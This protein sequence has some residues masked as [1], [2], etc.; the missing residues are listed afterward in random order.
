[1][2][3][4]RLVLP[5]LL[6]SV[7]AATAFAVAWARSRSYVHQ[8]VIATG[9]RDGEYYAFAQALAT[10]IARHQPD[11]EITVLETEGAAQN[12][13]L[14]ESGQAQLAIVQSDT[15]PEPSARA[16]AF[17]FPEVFHLVVRNE[18][19]I[20]NFADLLGKRVA[21]MPEGSG[22]YQLFWALS[23]H[24]GL[25]ATNFTPLPQ[26]P[27]QAYAALQ[28]GEVDALARVMA[29]GNTS[30]ANLL[31]SS[32]S[33]LVAIDQTAALRLAIP[34]LE[35]SE[36]PRGTYDG[37]TPIPAEDLPIIGVRAVLISRENVPPEVIRSVTQ[38]LF[39][40]RSEIVAI[41]PRAA[42]MRLPEAI[43][44]LGLPLHEGAQ[45]YYEKDTPS[46]LVEYAE[47]MG[48][49]VSVSV[50]AISSLWQFRLWL[51]GRQKNR[52]DM[53]NLEILSLVEQ[54]QA[55]D[56]LKELERARTDLF[57]ILRKVVV[58]LD[59]DRISPESFQSFTFPWEV[60]ITTLRHQQMLLLTQQAQSDP[61]SNPP[62][63][64]DPI[65]PMDHPSN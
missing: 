15:P 32:G 40:F 24:Y 53:Y 65:V 20:N 43:E 10:V 50:L 2:M 29:L 64:I 63:E 12:L 61:T 13:E 22:S 27:D 6:L 7:I 9:S 48:L 58:D 31:K 3:R 36:I 59:K 37:A 26:S 14:L 45:S 21:I 19:G 52:A 23:Q 49:L 54:V 62:L 38:T 16:V 35:A 28:R 55:I 41:Y 60:A 47:P 1:M 39:E 57:E 11:I 17:L 25:E 46:F 30:M 42:L 51:N 33:R 18:S 34:Y 5:I 4:S 44:N 8:L 56:D